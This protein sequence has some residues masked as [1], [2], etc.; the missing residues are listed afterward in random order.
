MSKYNLFL[1]LFVVVF[2]ICICTFIFVWFLQVEIPGASWLSALATNFC[3][4]KT[5]S[6]EDETFNKI[7]EKH[8]K[9]QLFQ[10][11][12]FIWICLQIDFP[13]RFISE[14]HP[15]HSFSRTSLL[16]GIDWKQLLDHFGFAQKLQFKHLLLSWTD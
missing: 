7:K 8:Q 16:P 6:R 13:P 1:C 3:V 11:N 4:I 15:A 14:A 9:N 2:R 5:R 10:S 12:Q